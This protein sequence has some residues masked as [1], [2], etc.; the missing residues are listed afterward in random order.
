M[1]YEIN[2]EVWHQWTDVHNWYKDK[3]TKEQLDQAVKDGHV[4]TIQIDVEGTP[5]SFTAYNDCDVAMCVAR[6]K[7]KSMEELDVKHE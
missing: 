7:F 2:G 6:H 3:F 5:Y 4:R 1:R